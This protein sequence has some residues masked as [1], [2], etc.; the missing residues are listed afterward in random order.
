MPY[1]ALGG[2]LPFLFFYHSSLLAHFL[3]PSLLFSL[4]F[5]H[6]CFPLY[7]SSFYSSPSFISRFFS[8]HFSFRFSFISLITLFLYFSTLFLSHFLAFPYDSA[9]IYIIRIYTGFVLSYTDYDIVVSVFLLRSSSRPMHLS[10]RLRGSHLVYKCVFFSRPSKNPI[11]FRV[12]I[13]LRSVPC[14]IS[15]L[16]FLNRTNIIIYIFFLFFYSIFLMK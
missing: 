11:S 1:L 6:F 3:F 16:N 5:T 15:I 7:R 12:V 8:F 9:L 2:F 14:C 10:S 13:P 4:R